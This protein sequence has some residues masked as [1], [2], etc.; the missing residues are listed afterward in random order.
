VLL[1]RLERYILHENFAA[2]TLLACSRA[3]SQP[4]LVSTSDLTFRILLAL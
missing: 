3:V 4:T 1:K 2:H